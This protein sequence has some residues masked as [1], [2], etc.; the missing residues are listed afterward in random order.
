MANIVSP[1]EVVV[2][3]TFHI[4][5]DGGGGDLHM[6]LPYSMIEPVREVL[7]AGVQSDI[8]EIDDRWVDSLRHDILGAKVPTNA[9]IVEREIKL[10]ELVDLQAGDIIPIDLPETITFK[11]N[12][13]PLFETKL[14]QCGENL[15]LK[16][17]KNI[18]GPNRDIGDMKSRLMGMRRKKR[19]EHAVEAM[20][21]VVK[22]EDNHE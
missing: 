19:D 1:S 15:A 13:I 5:L 2:V 4:A 3:S 10:G 8:D 11:A 21:E 9:T 16:V 14:G 17:H 20:A 7:D 18:S 6:T 12:N 22:Q